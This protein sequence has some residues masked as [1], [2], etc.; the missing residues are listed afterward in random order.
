[1]SYLAEY[2]TLGCRALI[3]ALAEWVPNKEARILD[4]AAGS[5]FAG[6][7]VRLWNK[8]AEKNTGK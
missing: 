3:S 4:V 8:S 6:K 1:M 5:G 2:D 7:E